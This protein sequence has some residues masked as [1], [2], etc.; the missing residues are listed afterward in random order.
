M[1][2]N[3]LPRTLLRRRWDGDK[4]LETPHPQDGA[5]RG[6]LVPRR[7]RLTDARA[8]IVVPLLRASCDGSG[9]CCGL[10]HHVPAT[11]EDRDGVVSALG[12][13]WNRTVALEDVFHPA[14]EGLENPLNVVSIDGSCAFREPDGKCAIHAAAG[15]GAKPQSCL[16]YPAHL[17]ACGTEW[18][19][20]LRPECACI[21]RSAIGGSALDA[22]PEVWVALR[23]TLHRVW[24]VP[25]NVN[26]TSE[27]AIPRDTYV[28]WMRSAVARLKTSFD[29]LGALESS[30][31]DLW[32]A[33]GVETAPLG[34][35]DGSRL[36]AIARHLA[37]ESLEVGSAFEES[38]PY[39]R[40]IEWGAE[41]A[42]ALQQTGEQVPD[43]SRGRAGDWARRTASTVSFLLHGH[44]LLEREALGPALDDLL[45]VLRLARAGEALKAT[46]A[47]DSRLESVTMW[48][49]L[50][51][52]VWL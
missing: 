49:F 30:R 43:W 21:T 11:T 35:P 45:H 24:A 36:D 39:R 22:D 31:A 32:S 33:A 19:A 40:S 51:R 16:S 23:K 48:L 26:I 46:E 52:N 29:P 5:R 9:A 6:Q 14:F 17:V 10:Y 18:H 41:V 28:D 12:D 50:W 27:R 15:A 44:T 25:R 3:D 47:V 37:A 8:N 34:F 7:V 2:A 1:A 20:S 38:S 13:S 42:T 4:I